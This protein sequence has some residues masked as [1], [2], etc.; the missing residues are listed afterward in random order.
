[1]PE[2]LN[3]LPSYL[4]PLATGQLPGR[5]SQ[6][7]WPG[8]FLKIQNINQHK[9]RCLMNLN[10][11][12][13]VFLVLN[14]SRALQ[15]KK[16]NYLNDAKK[17]NSNLIKFFQHVFCFFVSPTRPSFPTLRAHDIARRDIIAR[18]LPSHV[19]HVPSPIPSDDEV[20]QE[21]L[22]CQQVYGDLGDVPTDTFW[23]KVCMF[24]QKW[25]LLIGKKTG[26]GWSSMLWHREWWVCTR[27]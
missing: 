19:V 26:N 9:F 17:L 24:K 12:L 27:W 4:W 7:R 5:K 15:W 16:H 23:G 18:C 6:K 10:D 13:K 1:M 20:H 11:I 3:V 14:F 25:T 22:P 2:V 21:L 8:S